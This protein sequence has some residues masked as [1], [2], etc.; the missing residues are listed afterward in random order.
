M[1]LSETDIERVVQEVL[2]RLKA[3]TPSP[4]ATATTRTTLSLT[5]R[6]VT[7]AELDGKLQGIQ[8]L[9]VPP[10]AVVT[11]AARDYLRDHGVQLARS[12]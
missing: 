10:R 6:L 1:S 7:V 5:T 9:E 4:L 3:M 12:G 2:R 8:R 11:P